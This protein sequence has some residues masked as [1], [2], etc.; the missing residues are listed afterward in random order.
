MKIQDE[1]MEKIVGG[2]G[3]SME[4]DK[5]FKKF[6]SFFEGGEGQNSGMSSRAEMLDAF[7]KWVA[8]GIPDDIENWYKKAFKA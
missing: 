2:S 6:A 3:Y 8:D 5:L 7:K 1:M 4:D